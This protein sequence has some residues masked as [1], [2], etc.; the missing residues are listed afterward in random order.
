MLSRSGSADDG[1]N[2]QASREAP[3][4]E[5]RVKGAVAF[6]GWDSCHGAQ[7][8]AWAQVGDDRFLN[9]IQHMTLPLQIT[10]RNLDRSAALERWVESKAA[11][12]ERF[13]PEIMSCRVVVEA[14]HRRRRTGTIFH[15]RVDLGV[16]GGELVAARDPRLHHAHEDVYVAVRD[17][18]RAARR[19]L[20]DYARVRRQKVK[21]H[22]ERKPGRVTKLFRRN[23]F[24]EARDGREIYFR[25][26]SV[27]GGFGRLNV[28][29]LVRFVEEPGE[30]GPQASTVQPRPCSQRR[31][32]GSAQRLRPAGDPAQAMRAP[33]AGR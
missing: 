17:T 19:V 18:F 22:P 7:L 26:E 28:G 25:A 27:L 29:T 1:G 23:G 10:F 9:A 14:P 12:L 31:R 8:Y 13:F 32:S 15:V 2:H 3:E 21:R 4:P 16:P 20:M 24:L 5:A 11:R 6:S 33:R 30:R